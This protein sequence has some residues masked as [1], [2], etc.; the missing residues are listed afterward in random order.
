MAWA[1]VERNASCQEQQARKV[2]KR[3]AQG[4]PPDIEA[5]YPE[6]HSEPV[7]G[8]FSNT[9]G[10]LLLPDLLTSPRVLVDLYDWENPSGIIK[11]YGID[12]DF[13]VRLRDGEHI[14]LCANLEPE[15]YRDRPWLHD[16]LADARTIFRSLRSPYYFEAH[17]PGFLGARDDLRARLLRHLARRPERE[18]KSLC[19]IAN[20]AYAPAAP[21]ELANMLSLWGMRVKVTVPEFAD[22]I[23]RRLPEKPEDV[24][25]DLRQLHFLAATPI[26]AG[27]GGYV[28]IYEDK[29]QSYF[30]EAVSG[31]LLAHEEVTRL[32]QLNDFLIRLV[33]DL[34]PV[35]LKNEGYWQRLS[36]RDKEH[37]LEVLENRQDREE[38]L[39]AES[40]LRRHI[41]EHGHKDWSEQ[42][43]K[44]Y[45]DRLVSRV[46]TL[47]SV[48]DLG[49]TLAAFSFLWLRGAGGTGSVGGAAVV[50]LL[51]RLLGN[52]LSGAPVHRLI[53]FAI[54]KIR[55][56]RFIR[57]HGKPSIV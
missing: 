57:R 6:L 17:H 16:L 29:L 11:T 9:T 10:S 41:A 30:P 45:A 39:Q 54:P 23:V 34:S 22:E 14:I 25:L 2:A 47:G 53:E 37:I 42:E 49:I 35:D 48:A 4:E 26:S 24:L 55:V 50:F 1:D 36:Q 21:E 51:R 20:A 46:E 3:E 19:K 13:L 33:F 8:A 52:R 44:K 38:A 7:N 28:R 5:F 15:R 56:A 27:L 31:E 43:I 12:L 40:I 18:I 32:R